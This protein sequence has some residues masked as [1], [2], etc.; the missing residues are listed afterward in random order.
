MFE[1]KNRGAWIA[2]LGTAVT[3]GILVLALALSSIKEEQK[4]IEKMRYSVD[5]EYTPEVRAPDVAPIAE[6]PK[7][8]PTATPEPRAKEEIKRRPNYIEFVEKGVACDVWPVGIDEDGQMETVDSE[9]VAGWLEQSAAPGNRGNSIIAGH[10]A[11]SKK[12][13]VFAVL[14]ELKVGD[15]VRVEYDVGFAEEFT[16]VSVDIYLKNEVPDGALTIGEESEPKLTLIT[17]LG[18]YNR[19]TG[20]SDHRVVATCLPKTED[21]PDAA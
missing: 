14:K 9:R 6:T 2:I 16:V 13:G 20:T 3:L 18:D 8:E 11:Y 10:I 19:D 5:M 15:T 17:C 21:K 12:K 4:E 1:D 7:V